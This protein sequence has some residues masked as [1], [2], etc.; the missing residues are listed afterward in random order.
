MSNMGW[1][2]I[3]RDKGD[4]QLEVLPKIVRAS[5]I[6]KQKNYRKILDL[7]C[8]TGKHSIYLAQKGFSVYATDLSSTGIDIAKQ[9]A[10]SLNLNNITFKQHDMRNI[11]FPNDFFAAVI[12]T[13]TIYHGTLEDIRKTIREIYRVLHPNGM[14]ITDFLSTSDS[15]YGNGQEIETNTFIG[16]KNGEEDIPH[17][18]T[19]KEELTQLFSKFRELKMR[20]ATKS[21]FNEAS[22]RY[23]RKY[24]NV[25]VI[26]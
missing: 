13:W 15:T 21:Y 7:G 17:H 9:K 12:C 18:Y 16:E 6:F 19:K 14:L 25:E 11:P 23:I 10:E 24:Y 20:L 5:K 3:Y 2:R 8:G 26:K 1:E 22:E 4:L